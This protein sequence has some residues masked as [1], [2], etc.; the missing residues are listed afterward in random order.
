MQLIKFTLLLSHLQHLNLRAQLTQLILE[1][2]ALLEIF[3]PKQN[4]LHSCESF[5]AFRSHFK[6]LKYATESSKAAWHVKTECTF[7]ISESVTIINT[8]NRSGIEAHYKAS[9]EP[10]QS[11]SHSYDF[12]CIHNRICKT[13]PACLP[14]CI[15]PHSCSSTFHEE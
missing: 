2:L 1:M 3:H 15:Q 13:V 12:W 11:R 8:R 10:I 5:P 9:P 4:I 6:T 7:N 14:L